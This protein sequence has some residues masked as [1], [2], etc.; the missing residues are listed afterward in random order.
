MELHDTINKA[1]TSLNYAALNELWGSITFY[2]APLIIRKYSP[3]TMN[4]VGVPAAQHT[5]ANL[6]YKNDNKTGQ[7][8]KRIAYE[9]NASHFCDTFLKQ[10]FT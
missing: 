3:K 2:R 1:L 10:V 5:R 6:M 4:I 8:Q 9:E 7:Q